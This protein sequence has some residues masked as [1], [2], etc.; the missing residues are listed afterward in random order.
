[1]E[2]RLFCFTRGAGL[3]FCT[4]IRPFL[5]QSGEKM[6]CHVFV[7]CV[8]FVL[9]NECVTLQKCIFATHQMHFCVYFVLQ[10]GC[11]NAFLQGNATNNKNKHQGIHK[12]YTFNQKKRN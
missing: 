10:N 1:M 5:H 6:E 7:C 12:K 3:H 4:S 11:K 8:Y 2:S 9:Q